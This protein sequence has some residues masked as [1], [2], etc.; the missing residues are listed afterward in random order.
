MF[1]RPRR[2]KVRAVTTTRIPRRWLGVAAALALL[3]AACGDDD[4]GAA[5]PPDN[6]SATAENQPESVEVDEAALQAF[7]D[8][9]RTDVDAYGMTLSLRVPGHDD[10]HLASGIDDRD[11]ETPMPTDGTYGI[12]SVTKTFVATLA[13][14]LVDEGK[15]ALDE[16]VQAWLPELPHADEVTLAMLLGHTAG[17]GVWDNLDVVLQ[18]LTR[19]YT[20]EEALALNLQAPPVGQPGERFT[21]TNTGYTAVGL[22][23]ERVLHQDLAT[24]IAQR[25]TE[26]LS[27]D[28]TQ[29]ND[30]SVQASRHTWNRFAPDVVIDML[31]IPLQASMTLLF[32]AGTMISSSADLLDW[33]EAL[34]SGE[35]LGP[36]TTATM[37]DMRSS[38]APDP[39]GLVATDE[40]TRYH[41]GL[42]AMGYC[43]DPTG[44]DPDEVDLVGHSGSYNGYRTLLAYHPANGTT[45]TFFANTDVPYEQI[46][47]AVTDLYAQLGL[48]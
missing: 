3:A 33:G 46:L 4:D 35:L 22:M 19:S 17:F 15:L 24:A 48:T 44:C 2:S 42:G 1:P 13:L 27:L 25:F 30:G 36:E 38:F 10:I 23:I 5:V 41:Y 31:D 40:P 8:Q 34:Y 18:D 11:P 32:A 14:Q 28:D 7:L 9:W 45:L 20:P 29:M 12:A 37:L 26:T 39:A 47:P 16:P 6:E 43:L 21:Y